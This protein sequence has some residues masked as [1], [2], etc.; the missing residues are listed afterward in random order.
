[1]DGMRLDSALLSR[2]R[3]ELR[4]RG[5]RRSTPP[6]SAASAPT[7]EENAIAQRVMPFCEVLYLLMVADEQPDARELDVLRGAVRA[8]TNGRLGSPAIDRQLARFQSALAMQGREQRL[9]ELTGQLAA[10]RQ[11]AEAAYMLAAVMA[12]ADET[13]DDREQA[14]LEELRELLGI[15]ARRAHTLLGEAAQLSDEP[16]V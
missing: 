11:D 10:D 1:M 12:I 4:H 13:P 16:H 15:S 6:P 14:M 3:D 7:P 8:L 5:E 9:T 2:I